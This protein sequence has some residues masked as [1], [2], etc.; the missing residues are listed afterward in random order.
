MEMTRAKSASLLLH[1]WCVRS[2]SLFCETHTANLPNLRKKHKTPLSRILYARLP[3]TA[4]GVRL[5]L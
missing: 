5:G 1:C 2:V 3:S 4:C